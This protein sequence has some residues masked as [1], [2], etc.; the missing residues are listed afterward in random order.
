MKSYYYI[1]LTITATLCIS[2]CNQ[3][4]QICISPDFSINGKT[5]PS[6]VIGNPDIN[7][8]HSFLSY[9]LGTTIRLANFEKCEDVVFYIN[10]KKL[11]QSSLEYRLMTL[12]FVEIRAVNLKSK[13]EVRKFVYTTG[14]RKV[15]DT[16]LEEKPM[17]TLANVMQQVEQKE[18]GTKA[19][20]GD[21]DIEKNEGNTKSAISQVDATYLSQFKESEDLKKTSKEPTP[22]TGTIHSADKNWVIPNQGKNT[23]CDYP[24]TLKESSDY[25][26][27]MF[28]LYK[29]GN[30]Y[31]C[32]SIAN[33]EQSYVCLNCNQSQMHLFYSSYGAVDIEILNGEICLQNGMNGEIIINTFRKK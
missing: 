27:R 8:S 17:Q 15:Q 28:K 30:S 5:V 1:L 33:N 26:T 23:K 10:G 9:H 2:A 25:Y 24:G 21:I 32:T 16:G 12:G 18:E 19:S 22:F 4:D 20:L 11:A 7:D 29:N 13:K 31:Y 3:T 6:F 14:R